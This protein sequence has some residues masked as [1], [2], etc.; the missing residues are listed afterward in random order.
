MQTFSVLDGASIMSI[1]ELTNVRIRARSV[2]LPF[3]REKYSNYVATVVSLGIQIERLVGWPAL[4]NLL[5]HTNW[6]DWF[7]SLNPEAEKQVRALICQE[8]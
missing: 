4:C 8:R 1:E 3:R 2:R 6:E 5:H 7:A